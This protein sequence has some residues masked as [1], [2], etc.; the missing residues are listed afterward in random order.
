MILYTADLHFGHRSVIDFDH[1]LFSDVEEMDAALIKLWNGYY[2]GHTHIYGHIHNQRSETYRFMR[3]R[4]NAL[5]AGC[6]INGYS[7]VSLRELIRNN[8][9]WNEEIGEAQNDAE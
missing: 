5:N 6:M 2:K 8:E 4:Q 9:A 7:P 3:T 1:R